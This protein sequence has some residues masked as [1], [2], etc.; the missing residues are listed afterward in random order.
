LPRHRNVANDSGALS[1]HGFNRAV[2]AAESIRLQP[3]IFE[4]L[5]AQNSLREGGV[6]SEQNLAF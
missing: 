4:S 6:K 2:S 3:L 1:G 5:L